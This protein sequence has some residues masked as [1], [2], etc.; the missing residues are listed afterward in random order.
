MYK[1]FMIEDDEGIFEASKKYGEKYDLQFISVNNFR[2][3]TEELTEIN[4]HL[5]IMDIGLPA[6]DGYYWCSKIREISL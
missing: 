4:P 6:F 1:I 2:K 5:V 3:I